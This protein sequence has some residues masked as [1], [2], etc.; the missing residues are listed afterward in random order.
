MPQITPPNSAVNMSDAALAAEYSNACDL[1]NRAACDVAVLLGM[2]DKARYQKAHI[3]FVDAYSEAKFLKLLKHAVAGYAIRDRD[4]RAIERPTE[5]MMICLRMLREKNIIS[6]EAYWA[7][8]DRVYIAF[9]AH[10]K[11]RERSTRKQEEAEL[12][13]AMD[14]QHRKNC[15]LQPL[16]KR[17]SP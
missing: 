10:R 13:N 16:L 8:Y 17:K 3:K 12:I 15:T 2:N 4:V 7:A 5:D 11:Q 9:E 14:E 6:K 1:Q